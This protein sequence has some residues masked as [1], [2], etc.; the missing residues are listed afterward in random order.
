MEA[1]EEDREE[2]QR[3]IEEQAWD[4]RFGHRTSKFGA[5]SLDAPVYTKYGD[6]EDLTLNDIVVEAEP[7]LPGR[8]DPPPRREAVQIDEYIRSLRARL[9]GARDL[10]SESDRI[11]E[12]K[13]RR[14]PFFGRLSD[15]DGRTG[16]P[17]MITCA[18]GHELVGDNLRV[19]YI[20][21]RKHPIRECREC[22]RAKRKARRQ[23]AEGLRYH[24]EYMRKLRWNK[25]ISSS[26]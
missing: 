22:I 13:R 2:L 25:N 16:R 17:R 7:M 15:P 12:W 23:T 4:D 5:I 24:R 20:K 11:K 6:S 10:Q 3:L 9:P 14:G 21:G 18:E 8:K 19:R 26:S 1:R